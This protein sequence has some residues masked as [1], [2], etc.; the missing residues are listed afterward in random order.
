VDAGVQTAAGFTYA[1]R[2]PDAGGV[3][4]GAV[5]PDSPAWN[6][7]LRPGDLIVAADDKPVGNPDDFSAYLG[8]LHNWQT[9]RSLGL[10][11]KHEGSS[12]ETA[13]PPFT[14][15][16]LG[17]YPTQLYESVSMVLLLLLL[18]AYEPFKRRD[19]QV[20]ALLMMGYAV[21][22]YLNEQLRDDP[23]P[24]GFERYTSIVLLAAGL[25]LWLWLQLRPVPAP[26]AKPALAPAGA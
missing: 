1:G 23:R 9:H 13:L 16:T 5:A 2:Q 6:A 17:L 12:E 18:F 7:G 22:R 15:H 20:M 24:V 19:G 21:H 14:P 4:V 8:N 10:V 11:V 26:Q 25:A 3:R